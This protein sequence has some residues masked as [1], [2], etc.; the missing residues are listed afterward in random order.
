M[1]ISFL[2]NCYSDTPQGNV[3]VAP[4]MKGRSRA[5]S[6]TTLDA[7]KLEQSTTFGDIPSTIEWTPCVHV[8]SR[9][10]DVCKVG[11]WVMFGSRMVGLVI[12]A[13]RCL[14]TD[15]A[16]SH[17]QTS[18]LAE[19]VASIFPLAC[20]TGQQHL[21]GLTFSRSEIRDTRCSTC[22]SCTDVPKLWP[23]RCH[24]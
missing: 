8:I 19:Y 22:R 18:D 11:N 2:F 4:R 21:S 23:L 9:V 7:L 17:R 12:I 15:L 13:H 24:R 3:R 1:R 10:G 20:M 6:A 16:A 14:R 5:L